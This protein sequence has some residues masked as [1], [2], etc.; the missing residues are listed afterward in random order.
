M[1]SLTLKLSQKKVF[2]SI[3]ETCEEDTEINEISND[4]F[5]FRTQVA[6]AVTSDVNQKYSPYRF[7]G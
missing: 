6:N 1:G 7:I 3:R 5:S 2:D 4:W